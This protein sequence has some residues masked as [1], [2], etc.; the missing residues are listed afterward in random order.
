[1][2][3]T[4]RYFLAGLLLDAALLIGYPFFINS[5]R[6]G[7]CGRLFAF[8]YDEACTFSDFAAYVSYYG[9]LV[10][11]FLSWLILPVL[12]LPPFVGYRMDKKRAQRIQAAAGHRRPDGM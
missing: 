7:R 8:L 1:M 10:F 2:R 9:P 5:A 3:K 11:I 12:M 4:H 6:L